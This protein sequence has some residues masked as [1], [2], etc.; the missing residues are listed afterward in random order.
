[1]PNLAITRPVS[2]AN[3]S[4]VRWNAP[5]PIKS[6]YAAFEINFGFISIDD[7][8]LPAMLKAVMMFYLWVSLRSR[9]ASWKRS[10]TNPLF[11]LDSYS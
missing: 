11:L 6:R 5:K 2:I 10:F 7:A 8:E 1:L 9:S 4:L 3:A